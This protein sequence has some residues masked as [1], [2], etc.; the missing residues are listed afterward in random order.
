MNYKLSPS[1]FTFLFNL[2]SVLKTDLVYFHPSKESQST[3]DWLS[4]DAKF[5]TTVHNGFTSLKLRCARD[6]AEDV[7]EVENGYHN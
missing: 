7:Q 5:H 2:S 1:D 6:I 4:H 3:V